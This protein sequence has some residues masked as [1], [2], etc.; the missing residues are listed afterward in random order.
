M[1]QVSKNTLNWLYNILSNDYQDAK[2]TYSDVVRTL[3]GNSNFSIR[4]NVYT[5]EDGRSALLLNITGT[6]PVFFRGAT[7]MFPISLW[8][9]QEYPRTAPIA[10]VT[11]TKN[12]AVRAGQYVS[13]EGRVYH[14]YL[15]GWKQD[16]SSIV[17]LLSI[18]Q[19]VFAREPPVISRQEPAPH[20]PTLP[21]QSA[22]IPPPVPPL[23]PELGRPES[24]SSQG[25]SQYQ[26][27]PPP[28]PPKATENDTKHRAQQANGAP[29]V[30]PHPDRQGFAAPHQAVR[31]QVAGGSLPPISHSQQY[32][33]QR[34]GSL[35]NDHVSPSQH[36]HQQLTVHQPSPRSPN[37]FNPV[38][39]TPNQPL[40]SQASYNSGQPVQSH[41]PSQWQPT[42]VAWS[43]SQNA[44][45]Q[46]PSFFQPR[47]PP[48]QQT[49]SQNPPKPKAQEDLLT[50]PFETTL[51]TPAVDIAPP[52]IPPNP[53][54]DALLQALSQ[55]L[56]QQIQ[57]T[58]ASNM[59]AIPPLRA[60]QS[61]LNDALNSVNQEIAQLNDLQALLDSNE[62]IL[63]QAMLDADK[64]LE[65]AKRR[66]V[67]AVEEVLVAP[68]VVAGQLY[69]NVVEER[70]LE[71]CRTVVGKALDKGRIGGDVWAKVDTLIE[72]PTK[73]RADILQQT[74]S[75][76][77]EEFLKKALIKK[78]SR[79]MG[80]TQEEGWE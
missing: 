20:P 62:K 80:L 8:I 66:D 44:W 31:T 49:P 7:Y 48:Y 68:T 38:A 2:R 1:A 75:L 36:P 54:K 35:R 11:P 39:P 14:P 58:H 43:D 57:S 12:M 10:F 60:Q 70:V 74:R 64:V 15:A 63:R 3:Q 52:P 42:P 79:G 27:D 6:L 32:Q 47:G 34:V 51:P 26:S 30:P 53:Q 72:S 25:R 71:E 69:E 46:R 23:P 65:D 67:P 17:E 33:P 13:V 28:R 9:P 77:R 19:E 18:L 76:A 22:S 37:T 29:P 41:G 40:S 45:Q 24:V 5:F 50:S 61:A 78:I 4:T 56:T 21:Q 73:N 55:T 59:A 16:R